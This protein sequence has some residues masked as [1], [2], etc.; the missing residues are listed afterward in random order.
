MKSHTPEVQA[1]RFKKWAARFEDFNAVILKEYQKISE[2]TGISPDLQQLKDA[3]FPKTKNGD[4]QNYEMYHTFYY[5]A[6]RGLHPSLKIENEIYV[7]A[8][9]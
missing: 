1:L 4:T 6:S 5:L 7:Q 8:K 9:S 3:V 2:R